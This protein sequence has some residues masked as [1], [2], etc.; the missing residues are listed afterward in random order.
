MFVVIRRQRSVVDADAK[1]TSWWHAVFEGFDEIV[2]DVGVSSSPS[3][4]AWAWA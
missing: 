3:S 4:L 2:V 1:S